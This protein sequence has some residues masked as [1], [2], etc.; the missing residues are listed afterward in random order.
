[1]R[2]GG[3]MIGATIIAIGLVAAALVFAA[4]NTLLQGADGGTE[5]RLARL[6]SDLA[7][8]EAERDGLRADLDAADAAIRRLNEDVAL[9]RSTVPAVGVTASQQVPVEGL[10]TG[11]DEGGD[12]VE[13]PAVTEQMKLAKERFNKGLTQPRPSMML[14]LLGN[15]RE[16]YGTD[17]RP[18][19]NPRLLAALET[20]QIANVRVT[21]LRP[22]LESL[23][24]VMDRLKAEEPDIYEKLGTAGALCARFIRGSTTAISNHSWATAIDLTL[25]GE[26]DPF[27]DGGTQLGLVILAEHFNAEGWYWGAGYGREDSM[28]FEASE[29]LIRK[30]VAEGQ[31]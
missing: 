13:T 15:P 11:A 30:W 25:E 26:L 5:L 22:A 16:D 12:Y 19:T 20:R 10:D 23:Q 17:C 3:G 9:L 18:M 29:E 2:S 4:V 14:Q 7:T 21:M 31:I 27:A 1:M 24:R 8:A 28:H 6:E